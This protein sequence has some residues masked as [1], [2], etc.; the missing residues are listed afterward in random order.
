MKYLKLYENFNRINQLCEEYNITGYTITQDGLIDTDDDIN[1]TQQGFTS[2]PL[3]FGKVGFFDCSCNQLTTLFGSP[4]EVSKTFNCRDNQLIN[5]EGGPKIVKSRYYGEQNNLENLH[6]F[7]EYIF[8]NFAYFYLNPVE[9]IIKLLTT[10]LK[11]TKQ[12]IN[13]P[14]NP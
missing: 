10:I 14:K 11:T 2:L 13:N 9:E 12:N 1:L 4:I 3:K 6:G 5:L 7:P 8:D